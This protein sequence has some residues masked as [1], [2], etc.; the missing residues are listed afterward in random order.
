MERLGDIPGNIRSR[1]N[2]NGEINLVSTGCKVFTP[3][4]YTF[5]RAFCITISV[6]D[7]YIHNEKY[8]DQFIGRTATG[9]FSLS[10]ISA[11][12]PD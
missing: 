9:I 7:R 5:L 11:V 8:G 6:K 10:R 3:M 1:Y 12:S 4:S 2:R